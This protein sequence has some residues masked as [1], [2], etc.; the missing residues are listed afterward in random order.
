MNR[1]SNMTEQ[2]QAQSEKQVQT[3]KQAQ[4]E[5]IK[6]A[7]FAIG[8]RL[9]IGL[10]YYFIVAKLGQ[11]AR[12]SFGDWLEGWNRWDA[13]HYLNLAKLGYREYQEEGQHLFL[14]FL[15]LY[16]L[17]VRVVGTLV[18]SMGLAAI[19]IS[20]FTY[21]F[22]CM[23]LYRLVKEDYGERAAIFAVISYSVFP[24]SFYFGAMMTES[25]FFLLAVMFIYYLKRE[26]YLLTGILGIL[27]CL[28]KL[29]G[30]FLF[31]VAVVEVFDKY[32]VFSLLKAKDLK[33]IWR[34]IFVPL[35]KCAIMVLGV[36]A[37]LCL[38]YVVER[39]CF[40]FMTYQREHWT[41][42]LGP[43]WNTVKYMTEY[44]RSDPTGEIS[45]CIWWP[46]VILLS[47]QTLAVIYAIIKKFRPSYIA[48]IIIFCLV[49]YSSTWIISGGRY[50][51][52]TIPLF[53][54]AG[55]IFS[56]HPRIG[57]L[58]CGGSFVLMIQ[59]LCAY[60][61]WMPVM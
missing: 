55:V 50:T 60:F 51:L 13:N 47:L 48:Y 56:K 52:T 42:T 30:G 19:L 17:L 28:T 29:Q 26:K 43:I 7:L 33:E 21:V 3:K 15:P 1:N 54:L 34:K 45:L 25:L 53:I 31:F 58:V 4:N 37:Y 9:L 46:Q 14:V 11:T 61:K 57:A 35:F 18:S 12:P 27:C 32:K 40:A 20:S 16:P 6:I 44:L 2:K 22:G 39:D 36:I 5:Q 49:T 8:F 23:Y 10:I 38:N 41:H 24:F 59:Y